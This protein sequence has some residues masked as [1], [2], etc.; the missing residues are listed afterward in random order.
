MK[1][2]RGRVTVAEIETAFGAPLEHRNQ[3]RVYRCPKCPDS[4]EP[5]LGINVSK[6]VFNCYRCGAG[7]GMR[8]KSIFEEYGI[9]RPVVADAPEEEDDQQ[10]AV[11]KRP[12]HASA[13]VL[14]WY[15]QLPHGL[16]DVLA[17]PD[18]AYAL[19]YLKVVR[20]LDPAVIRRSRL[21]YGSGPWAGYVLFPVYRAG[22]MVFYSGRA[23]DLSRFPPHM[24]AA[25][26]TFPVNRGEVLYGM[27]RA[28]LL[29]WSVLC[30]APLDAAKVNIFAMASYG[31][32]VTAQ[33]EEALQAL[34]LRKLVIYFDREPEAQRLAWELAMRLRGGFREGVYVAVP[35]RK[36]PNACTYE[37]NRDAVAAGVLATEAEYMRRR[38]TGEWV[39]A[40]LRPAAASV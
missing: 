16:F 32:G 28:P 5:K 34:K 4:K 37:E 2:R 39:G 33:Q 6:Q 19:H 21:G 38:L 14:G 35:P 20:A 18:A 3:E 8:L 13:E 25:E 17:H 27:D 36:D 24:H 11:K 26:G 12:K 7:K 23:W 22:R 40:A 29:G 31:V 30:E 15:T 10:P 9:E 1:P